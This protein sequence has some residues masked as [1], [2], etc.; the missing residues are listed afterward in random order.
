MKLSRYLILLSRR[1]KCNLCLCRFILVHGQQSWY[2]LTTLESGTLEQKTSTHGILAKKHMSGL[3]IQRLQTK[4][5]CLCQTMPS[6]VVPSANCRSMQN[7]SFYVKSFLLNLALKIDDGY[8]LVLI[9]LCFFFRPQDIS[10]ATSIT[11]SR[12]KLF[13]TVLMVA[14]ALL[15]LSC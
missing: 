14:S 5:N 13:L 8:W 6:S 11:G 9:L 4:L 3:S 12:S 15:V 1:L 2:H 10:L 7:E